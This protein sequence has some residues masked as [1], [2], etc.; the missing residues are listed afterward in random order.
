LQKEHVGLHPRL[1]TGEKFS[2][3]KQKMKK[4]V[5]PHFPLIILL[6]LHDESAL[7]PAGL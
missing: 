6:C 1:V 3:L 5:K 7:F 2:I 4:I